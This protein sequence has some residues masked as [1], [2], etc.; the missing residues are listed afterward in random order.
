MAGGNMLVTKI[1]QRKQRESALV[2]TVVTTLW[3]QVRKG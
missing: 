1:S 3:K 2:G